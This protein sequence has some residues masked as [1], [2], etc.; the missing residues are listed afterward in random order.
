MKSWRVGT[1]S[2]GASLVFLGVFLIL[3]RIFHWQA[4]TVM[5]NWWPLLLIVLGVE[6]LFFLFFSKQE[7]P[8]IKYDFLSIIFVGIIG[9]I[10]ISFTIVTTTGILNKVTAVMSS[11]QRTLDLPNYDQIINENIKRIVVE[12][13]RYPLTIEGTSDKSISLFGTYVMEVASKQKIMDTFE[14]YLMVKE[15]GDTLFIHIKN[16]PDPH[17]PLMSEMSM[18]PILLVP[19]NVKLEVAGNDNKITMKPRTLLNDWSIDSAYRVDVQVADKSNLSIHT[20]NV[21]EITGISRT[22]EQKKKSKVI[23]FGS[24]DHTL[25]IS[26]TSTLNVT[27]TP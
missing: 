13:G 15:K 10:G 12:A 24:G 11:E 14:D 22:S 4:A 1:F 27:K 9:I 20:M 6:I 8:F 16:L 21:S 5:V 3:T 25:N 17:Q 7:K 2:M 19:T 18:A 23:K 26:R